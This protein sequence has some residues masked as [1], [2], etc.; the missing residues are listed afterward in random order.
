MFDFGSFCEK[1]GI[2]T[3]PPEDRH[4]RKGW[5]NVH[6]PFCQHP[7]RYHLG[8]NLS[9]C[10]FRC[11]RCGKHPFYRTVAV[12][13]GTTESG[14]KR[15]VNQFQTGF[16]KFPQATVKKEKI[17]AE[18]CEPP[19]LAEISK[20]PPCKAYKYLTKKRGFPEKVIDE[21]D[22][23]KV[24]PNIDSKFIGRIFFPY[25]AN[26][27]LVTYQLRDYT[28]QKGTSYLACPKEE[29]VFDVKETLYGMDHAFGYEHVIVV[30]GVFDVLNIGPGSVATSGTQWTT[31]QALILLNWRKQFIMFDPNDPVS[32]EYG[33]ELASTLDQ[34]G[35]DAYVIGAGA[36]QSDRDP[37]EF[38]DEEVRVLR[39]GCGLDIKE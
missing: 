27:Q 39:T 37:G 10:Y 23:K 31:S 38:N 28:E 16:T 3:A 9:Y 15:I 13:A 14:A 21:W 34:L 6:C 32:Y 19:P 5:I 17:R 25:Y 35:G 2:E 24:S 36:F 30:E 26:G 7:S 20:N 11:W 12:L 18:V 1:Y 33:E 8:Y 4:S 22:L 29:A